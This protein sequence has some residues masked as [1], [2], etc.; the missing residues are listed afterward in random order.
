MSLGKDTARIEACPSQFVVLRSSC[1]ESILGSKLCS[2]VMKLRAN[3][4]HLFFSAFEQYKSL[5][6]P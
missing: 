2:V 3:I 5:L 4:L 6:L 1:V